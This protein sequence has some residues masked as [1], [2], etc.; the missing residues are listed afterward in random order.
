MGVLS[1]WEAIE[2]RRG[3]QWPTTGGCQVRALGS[4]YE[5]DGFRIPR[6]LW[7]DGQSPLTALTTSA[8]V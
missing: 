6:S 5:T 1:T 2:R 7:T 4:K 8:H 3:S